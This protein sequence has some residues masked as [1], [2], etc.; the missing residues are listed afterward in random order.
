MC[1]RRTSSQ[2]MKQSDD[3][4]GPTWRVGLAVLVFWVM[5]GALYR[6][7]PSVEQVASPVHARTAPSASLAAKQGP[8]AFDLEAVRR[9]VH[10]AFRPE[11]A[12]YVG[13]D[14]TYAVS[15]QDGAVSL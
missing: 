2:M 15:A 9:Q 10:F 7:G 1:G 12:K 6:R 14:S 4:F 8:A 11:G 5:F 3:R 13:G